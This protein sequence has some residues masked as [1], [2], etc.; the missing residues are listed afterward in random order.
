MAVELT[1][2]EKVSPLRKYFDLDI[3]PTPQEVI[4]KV[5]KGDFDPAE[6]LPITEMNR[7]CSTD[8][9]RLT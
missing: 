5:M 2:E 4:D 6:A 8:S 1:E 9:L 3:K 7:L